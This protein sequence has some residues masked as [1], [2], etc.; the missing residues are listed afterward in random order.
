[1]PDFAVHIENVTKHYAAGRRLI[2]AVRG[3]SVSIERGEFV[4]ITG[5]SGCGKSTL[6]NLITGIDRADGGTLEILGV[7]LNQLS[8]DQLARWRGAHVGIVFQFFQLMPTLTALENI[9]LPM[10]LLGSG[11]DPTSRGEELLDRVGLSGLASNLPGELSGG[12]QQRVAI[13]RALANNPDIVVAD[14]PTGNLDSKTGASVIKLLQNVWRAGATLIIVT[15]DSEL[16]DQAPRRISMLD[17]Q[18]I[19]DR[20]APIQQPD[21]LINEHAAT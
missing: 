9:I 21:Y 6:L 17:G 15:H 7:E 3:I 4:T 5:P 20:R 10:D 16:A 1:M 8:Q 18:I 11:Q 19:E 2:P 14:E 12:E 13:A